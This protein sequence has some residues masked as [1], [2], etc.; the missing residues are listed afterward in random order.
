MYY[1]LSL[2]F[3]KDDEMAQTLGAEERLKKQKIID[4][5]FYKRNSVSKYPVRL[6]WTEL[7]EG[8]PNSQCAFFVP[9]RY[10]RHAVDRN[11]IKR[12]MRE[13]YRTHRDSYLSHTTTHYAFVLLWNGSDMPSYS[14]V[15]TL[16]DG[17][18]GK[19][20]EKTVVCL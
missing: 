7:D 18:F 11:R 1:F 8:S 16:I 15:C 2:D 14:T 17:A 12:L 5:I 4:E 3:V 10:L 19:W 20:K 9:K 13:A 6:L